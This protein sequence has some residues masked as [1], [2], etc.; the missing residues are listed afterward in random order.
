M[1]AAFTFLFALLVLAVQ[2]TVGL[3]ELDTDGLTASVEDTNYTDF[4]DDSDPYASTQSEVNSYESTLNEVKNSVNDLRRALEPLLES[5]P[6][7]VQGTP[8]PVIV[9]GTPRPVAAQ[10]FVAQQGQLLVQ[11]VAASV[12]VKSG[13]PPPPPRVK[14]K[15]ITPITSKPI[16]SITPTTP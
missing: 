5:L 9:Q 11:G 8:R 13:V 7:I 3:T 2:G 6:V 4:D 16:A 12:P 10:A 14:P 1:R 15:P